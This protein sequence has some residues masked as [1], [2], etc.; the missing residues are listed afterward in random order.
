MNKTLTINLGG[1]VFH[2]DES[3]YH[4]LDRYLGQLKAQ[5]AATQGGSEIIAD[6]ESRIAELFK[7]RTQTREVITQQDV[8]EIIEIMGKPE[9]YLYEEQEESSSTAYTGFTR[10]KSR[11]I[12]RDPDNRVIG[13]V[14]AGVAAYFNIDPIWI[15]IL[16]IVLFFTGPGIFIYL[17]MWLVIP[18]ASTT[19]EKLQMRGEHVTIENI[20]KSVKDGLHNMG[21]SARKYGEQARNFDYR[22]TARHAGGFFTD[23]GNFLKDAFRLIFK[24]LFKLI[25]IIFIIFGFI[26]LIGV[27]TSL[28]AGGVTLFASTYTPAELLDFV[29]ISAANTSHYQW[30]V[31]G[32]VLTV[33]A[34]LFLLFYLGIRMIFNVE[35]LNSQTRSGLALMTFVG[36][37]ITIGSGIRF[38]SEFDDTASNQQEIPLANGPNYYLNISND[39]I[40]ESFLNGDYDYW[41]PLN[42]GTHAIA[43]LE[44]DIRQS[45]NE[46]AYVQVN[47]SANGRTYRDAKSNA[48]NI[49]YEFSITDSII[50]L[51]AYILLEDDERF[52]YQEIYLVFYLPP[53]HSIYIDDRVTTFLDDVK[54]IQNEWD[55]NMGNQRWL[56]TEKGLTCEGCLLPEME[57]EKMDSTGTDSVNQVVQSTGMLVIKNDSMTYEI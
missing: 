34:P 42:S 44:V 43:H 51:P 37:I 26:I 5:F 27:L 1:F 36:I 30:L 14:S 23:L 50:D 32:I 2:I 10:S 13:G 4:Q 52:R 17:I 11:R 41:M 31:T 55:L 49:D 40:S 39:S 47:R 24:V 16:F 15:R 56:M 3:A 19:A 6:I 38:A 8:E 21:A 35:P 25:G 29:S 18:K 53:G 22:E 28:F 12:F 20:E 57:Q 48:R 7:E 33:V 46:Q 9:D 45:L 54:N